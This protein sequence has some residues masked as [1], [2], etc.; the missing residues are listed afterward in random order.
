M[1]LSLTNA[2]NQKY[3]WAFARD[4]T[5]PA[6]RYRPSLS[7]RRNLNRYYI[8]SCSKQAKAYGVTVGM[9]YKEARQL[10]PHMRVIVCNR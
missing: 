3:F 8:T 2:M 5:P 4:I 7:P 1:Q 6:K 10:V 9:T